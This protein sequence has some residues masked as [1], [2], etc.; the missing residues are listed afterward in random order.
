MSFTVAT[1]YIRVPELLKLR[2]TLE[3]SSVN[4]DIDFEYTAVVVLTT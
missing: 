4:I 1:T 3:L 2:P